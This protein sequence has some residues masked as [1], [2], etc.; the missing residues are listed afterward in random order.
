MKPPFLNGSRSSVR[1]RVPSGKDQERVARRGSTAAPASIDRI[2]ASL[3]RRSTGMKPP[4]PE[5]PRQDRNRVDLVLVED[6]H[7]R[8]QRVE[9]DRRVDVALM[10]RAE[11]GGAVERQVLGADRPD[12]GC[13]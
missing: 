11:D 6:V 10:V 5:R 13:R 9:Q 3:L 1:L 4:I 12:S 2:A 7:P 8:M